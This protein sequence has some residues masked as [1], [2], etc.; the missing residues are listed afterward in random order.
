MV[1]PAKDADGYAIPGTPPSA[2]RGC[3]KKPGLSQTTSSSSIQPWTATQSCRQK[4]MASIA[5]AS[6]VS[7]TE[8]DKKSSSVPMSGPLNCVLNPPPSQGSSIGGA[9]IVKRTSGRDLQA[10]IEKLF[11]NAPDQLQELVKSFDHTYLKL[12]APTSA[13]HLEYNKTLF[14]MFFT[15]LYKSEEKATKLLEPDAECPPLS[16]M[17]A[18]V[19]FSATLGRSGIKPGTLGWSLSTTKVFVSWIFQIH[20]QFLAKEVTPSFRKQMIYAVESWGKE[21]YTELLAAIL[22]PKVKLSSNYLRLEMTTLC[23]MF[24]NHSVHLST[25]VE[26]KYYISQGRYLMWQDLE[27]VIYGFTQGFR[28]DIQVFITFRHVKLNDGNEHRYIWTSMRTLGKQKM[29]LDTTLGLIALGIA[30]SVFTEDMLRLFKGDPS[31]IT[32]P[33]ILTDGP[34]T[35]LA[36]SRH[37]EKFSKVLKWQNFSS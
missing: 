36:F 35:C 5:S 29:H 20:A 18:F 8:S 19:W 26:N 31:D 10:Q 7:D 4:R 3:A 37:L 16:E 34:M 33:H 9:S 32:F 11:Q 2:C 25:I 14:L 12:I 1:P 22:T 28:L 17:V 24:F 13:R 23:G 21:D 27:F 6:T 15:V 30:D